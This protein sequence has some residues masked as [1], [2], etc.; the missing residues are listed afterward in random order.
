MVLPP[1]FTPVRAVIPLKCCLLKIALDDHA[2]LHR[3]SNAL[4]AGTVWIN[5][6]CACKLWMRLSYCAQTLPPGMLYNQVPFGGY[7][8][9]GIG[10]ELGSYALREYTNV[11]AVHWNYGEKLDWPL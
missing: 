11:K 9:S 10:R 1:L 8:Q 2:Q 6:Y 3:V 5:S 7:K 4:Q